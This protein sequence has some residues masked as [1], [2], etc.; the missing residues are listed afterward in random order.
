MIEAIILICGLG[1]PPQSC[2]EKTADDVIRIKVQPAICAMAAQ[3]IIAGEA[4]ARA[5]GRRMKV[6]CGG[7]A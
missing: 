3:S 6:I 4:G 2:T 1:L 7:K 5:K